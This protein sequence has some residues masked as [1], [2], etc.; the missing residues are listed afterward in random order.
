MP[1][2][3]R[4][5]QLALKGLEAERAKIDNEIAQIK[6]QVRGDGE[7]GSSQAE[8][9]GAA[10]QPKETREMSTAARKKIS[11]VVKRRY[12]KN[13]NAA[14]SPPQVRKDASHGRKEA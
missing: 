3:E 13:N 5:L 10:A 2:R 14:V 4:L 1:N 12:A 6:S 8:N 7:S 9:G 11:D